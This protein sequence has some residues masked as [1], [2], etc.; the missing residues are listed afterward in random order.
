[1]VTVRLSPAVPGRRE[2]E[3]STHGQYKNETTSGCQCGVI[4]KQEVLPISYAATPDTR[5]P[6]RQSVL[7]FGRIAK[8]RKDTSKQ[9]IRA[10]GRPCLNALCPERG[11]LIYWRQL[12]QEQILG[13]MP[14]AKPHL[15]PG[16]R[17]RVKFVLCDRSMLKGAG[18]PPA[19]P[20]R[21]SYCYGE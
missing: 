17:P 20:A 4:K 19:R 1:M 18:K 21:S 13:L 2:P 9:R 16:A 6:R 12:G 8:S 5:E 7:R 14:S 10:S 3:N 15:L 11:P